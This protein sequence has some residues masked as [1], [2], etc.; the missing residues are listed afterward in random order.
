MHLQNRQVSSPL[1]LLQPDS[2]RIAHKIKKD[3]CISATGCSVKYWSVAEAFH[4]SFCVIF[5]KQIFFPRSNLSHCPHEKRPEAF[6]SGA[7]VSSASVQGVVTYFLQIGNQK[8][9]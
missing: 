7:R 6:R 4:Y 5:K 1:R 9:F 2:I 8:S 3:S